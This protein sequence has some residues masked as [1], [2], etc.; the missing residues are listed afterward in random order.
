M[1]AV[2]S[3]KRNMNK[4]LLGYTYNINI[5]D[6]V[7]VTTGASAKGIRYVYV[8]MYNQQWWLVVVIVVFFN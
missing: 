3:N 6:D 5:V 7:A 1:G 2:V 8:C 4:L